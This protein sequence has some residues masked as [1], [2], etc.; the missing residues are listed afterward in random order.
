[1]TL[2]YLYELVADGRIHGET[3]VWKAG[4][5]DWIAL[6]RHKETAEDL[7]LPEQP[8]TESKP[9]SKIYIWALVLAPVWGTLLQIIA[10]ELWVAT[11]HKRLGY[12]SQLWWIMVAGN[13][14]A[15]YLDYASLKKSGKDIPLTNKWMFLLVPAYIYLRDS[16]IIAR[17]IWF[18]SWVGSL[19]LS[20]AAYIYLNGVYAH[21]S[22][23]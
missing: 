9:A 6:S 8:E 18:W 19:L 17:K 10:T 13:F 22:I 11:T 23:R 15:S 1:M 7:I 14:M 2:T 16:R 12:Y 3:S 21:L 20:L 4:M 5:P